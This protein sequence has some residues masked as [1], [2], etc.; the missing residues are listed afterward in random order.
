MSYGALI[1]VDMQ[2][3]LVES[4]PYNKLTVVEN[5]KSLLSACRKRKIP[6][7]YI[8]HDG[9]IGDELESGSI[10]WTIYKEIA[11]MENEKI[12]EKKYNSAFRKTGLKKYLD[13]MGIKNIILCGMQTEHCVDATCKVAFE[14]EYNITIPLFTTTTFDNGFISGKDL[15]EYYEN[16]IWN[17]RY[18][19]VVNV[20]Q[21]LDEINQ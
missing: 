10:G 4:L 2:T 3:S 11:P 18:A 17:N 8:Q 9:G 7:I 12:F 15:S 16:K 19:Q 1:I 6:V 13:N 14:Y 21:I 20:N 5:I